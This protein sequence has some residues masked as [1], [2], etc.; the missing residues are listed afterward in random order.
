MRELQEIYRIV[1]QINQ[2]HKYHLSSLDE[3]DEVLLQIK[4]E[5]GKVV[6]VKISKSGLEIAGEEREKHRNIVE[7][8]SKDL[9]KLIHNRSYILRYLTTG[10]VRVRGD[11]KKVLRILQTI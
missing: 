8:T 2:S 6:F 7:I 1:D 4:L 5:S 11:I 10:R 3:K 9:F